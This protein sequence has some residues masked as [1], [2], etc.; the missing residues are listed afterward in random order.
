MKP[1]SNK[2]R[3]TSVLIMLIVF[4]LVAPFLIAYST[5]YRFSLDKLSFFET[6]GIFIHNELANTRVY[7]DEELVES[8]G[9]LSKNTLV[10]NLGAERV[11][12]VRVEKEGHRSWSKELYVYPNL[13]TE[14]RPLMLATDIA[15][16]EIA[17][18][19]PVQAT[20]TKSTTT[21]TVRAPL[22]NLEYESV[23]LL[24]G[25]T[26][27]AKEYVF[28]ITDSIDALLATTSTST[29]VSKMIPGYLRE[30]NIPDITKKEQLQERW[31]TIAWLE[32]GNVHIMWAGDSE[33][34]PFYFC[35]VRGC[36]DKVIVSLDT[37]ITHFSFFPGRND[38]FI[39]E[40]QNHVFAVEADD[41]SKQNVEPIYQGTKPS[42][43]LMGNTIYVR[44]GEALYK[45]EI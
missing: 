14:G 44:D 17:K 12:R 30:L 33:N 39:V 1:L 21:K 42:F 9:L 32:D 23:S 2:Y 35:D 7:V 18:M 4:I 8:T 31:R 28:D 13:V 41:R 19:Q 6:G 15:F 27:P 3:N 20:S 24:F 36:R 25:T 45:A 29:D 40:T 43:R 11:Y 38:V 10:Q 37:A 26:T 5:G 22:I 34:V 16:E